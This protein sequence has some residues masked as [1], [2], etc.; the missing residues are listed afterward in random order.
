M[1]V[2]LLELALDRRH[3]HAIERKY[4]VCFAATRAVDNARKRCLRDG[5][6]STQRA[7]FTQPAAFAFGSSTP[8]TELF[9]VVERVF[10]ALRAYIALSTHRACGLRRTAA[11]GEEDLWVNLGAARV[12][13]PLDGLKKLGRDPLHPP[14]LSFPL[15]QRP[16]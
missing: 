5:A 14:V 2:F 3:A 6:Q 13:L 8:D 7:F 12:R 16:G 15:D 10:E 11:L 1:Q 4:K 9:F